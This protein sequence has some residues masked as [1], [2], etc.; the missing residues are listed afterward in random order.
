MDLRFSLAVPREA[1]SIPMIRR[2]VGDALRGLGVAE[3]CVTDILVAASEACTNVVQHSR[4]DGGFTVAGRVAGGTCL[5]SITDRGRGPRPVPPPKELDDLSESGR[6]IR[7]M[8]ALMDDLSIDSVPGSGTV[9]QLRK[10]LT[11]RD[12]SPIGRLGHRLLHSA[13]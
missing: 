6:G 7:I 4:A 10:R 8:R 3:D 11:W 9:V 2:V 1:P 5:L 13:G 12:E